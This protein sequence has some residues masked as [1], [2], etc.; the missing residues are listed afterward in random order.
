MKT[1]LW[2]TERPVL[3]FAHCKRCSLC[4][5]YCPENAITL[6]QQGYPAID[7]DHCKGCLLCVEQCPAH[8]MNA[9]PELGPAIVRKGGGRP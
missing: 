8:A 6:D 5:I 9:V 7:Y 2:R 3:D 4:A 1:G